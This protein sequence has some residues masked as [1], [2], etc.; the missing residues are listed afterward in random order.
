MSSRGLVPSSTSLSAF[1]CPGRVVDALGNPID[2]KGPFGSSERF[3]PEGSRH[4]PQAV[5]VRAIA[6]WYQGEYPRL[7]ISET[8]SLMFHLQA[9]ECWLP[10][11]HWLW[12]DHR[13]KADWQDRRRYQKK[14]HDTSLYWN[15]CNYKFSGCEKV[16]N[17]G[18]G[19]HAWGPN[20]WNG[21]HLV[22][23]LHKSLHFPHYYVS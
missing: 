17:W 11:A 7:D 12:A 10:C 1:E 4:Y 15:R 19:P 20:C 22:L 6:D 16:L 2:G 14:K 23:I 13:R 5:P 9:V 18:L 21:P 3:S 8:I